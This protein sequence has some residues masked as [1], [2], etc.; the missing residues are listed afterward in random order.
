L[1]KREKGGGK[2]RKWRRKMVCKSSI[3]QMRVR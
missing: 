2:W 1:R 3:S